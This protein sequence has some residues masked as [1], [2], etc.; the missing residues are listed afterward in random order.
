MSNNR[1]TALG[2]RPSAELLGYAPE[3][4]AYAEGI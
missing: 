3:D 1:G 4:D 2:P